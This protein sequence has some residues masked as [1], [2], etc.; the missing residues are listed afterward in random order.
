MLIVL[1]WQ[2]FKEQVSKFFFGIKEFNNLNA[3]H[4]WDYK[5]STDPY[6]FGSPVRVS[7]SVFFPRT[8]TCSKV[9][10]SF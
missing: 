4:N 10:R 3:N 9:E 2:V 7:S 5:W 8:T 6:Y 1:L